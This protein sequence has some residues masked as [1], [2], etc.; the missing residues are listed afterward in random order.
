MNFNI[1][2]S[3]GSVGPHTYSIRV[4][5]GTAGGT[6]TLQGSND[7][8]N[9]VTVSSSYSSSRTLS[10]SNVTTS[11]AIFV[12]TSNPYKYYRLSYTGTGTM[13]CKLQG[14]FSANN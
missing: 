4:G 13:S 7:G 11:T 2:D 9:F 3:P 5:R 12:V 1:V 6:V 8:V 14:Y 10:V